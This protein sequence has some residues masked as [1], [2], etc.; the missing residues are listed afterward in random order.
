MSNTFF[1]GTTYGSGKFKGLLPEYYPPKYRLYIEEETKLL[2]ELVQNSKRILEAGVGI[3]RLIPVLAPVVKDFVGIDNAEYMIEKSKEV[4]SHFPNVTIYK[5]EIEKAAEFFSPFYFEHTLCLWNTLG[6]VRNEE[7]IL[8]ILREITDKSIFITVFLKGTKKDRLELY[9]AIDVDIQKYD[10]ESE[11]FF[12]DGYVSRTY[13]LQDVKLL[14]TKIGLKIK[15]SKILGG[16]VLFV[17][18]VKI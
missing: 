2:L 12:L 3:G 10:E 15:Q 11:T 8:R 16:V 5:L 1:E 4:A 6:N 7:D 13:N 9:H 18:L 17:E 14:A